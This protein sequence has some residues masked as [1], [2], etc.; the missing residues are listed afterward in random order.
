MALCFSLV[1]L[2]PYNENLRGFTNYIRPRLFK[3]WRFSKERAGVGAPS[4]WKISHGA[5]LSLDQFSC[6]KK[7]CPQP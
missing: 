7:L 3:A 6:K 1:W 4:G 2:I 5:G